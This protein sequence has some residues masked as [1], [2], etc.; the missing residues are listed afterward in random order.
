MQPTAAKVVNFCQI[1]KDMALYWHFL[2]SFLTPKAEF[3]HII[4][5]LCIKKEKHTIPDMPSFSK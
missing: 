1:A 5:L 4:G 3:P 2:Y